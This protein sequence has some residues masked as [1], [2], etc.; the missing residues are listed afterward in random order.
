[1]YASIF[2]PNWPI[3]GQIFH[4][5]DKFTEMRQRERREFPTVILNFMPK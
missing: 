2:P 1:M 3:M 4:S 5:M